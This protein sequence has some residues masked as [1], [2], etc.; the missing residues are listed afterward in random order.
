[1]SMQR[2]S[3]KTR[4]YNRRRRRRRGRRPDAIAITAIDW[5]IES[6]IPSV[7]LLE[8]PSF[9]WLMKPRIKST[10]SG[11]VHNIMTGLSFFILTPSKRNV[12][13][14]SFIPIR[15][16]GRSRTL[17]YAYCMNDGRNSLTC[18]W[19]HSNDLLTAQNRA[20]CTVSNDCIR[21]AQ[22][23]VSIV[24]VCTT[25]PGKQNNRTFDHASW[26]ESSYYD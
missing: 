11:Y 7:P 2:R 22:R 17:F 4:Y 5:F 9:L 18:R 26:W 13:S 6:F 16:E 23:T 25:C 21:R 3:K 19:C 8:E 10:K 15:R 14:D 20:A 1:M 12:S 24:V